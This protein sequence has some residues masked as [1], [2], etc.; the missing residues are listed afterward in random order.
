M[1]YN[2]PPAFCS[3]VIDC[4]V[5]LYLCLCKSRTSCWVEIKCIC[6]LFIIQADDAEFA[7]ITCIVLFYDKDE[8]RELLEEPEQIENMCLEYTYLLQRYL[9]Q[10]K[11][12]KE[13]PRWVF[14]W[15][16]GENPSPYLDNMEEQ[17][18]WRWL[19]SFFQNYFIFRFCFGLEVPT[20]FPEFSKILCSFVTKRIIICFKRSWFL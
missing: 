8:F 12:N 7:L 4:L 10:R 5:L 11:R 1:N 9:C 13:F 3:S 14:V 19:F 17:K 15:E 20:D 18:S 16:L 2:P 6:I